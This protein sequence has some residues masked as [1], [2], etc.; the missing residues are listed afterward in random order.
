MTHSRVRPWNTGQR[1]HTPSPRH[2]AAS[3]P[4]TQ[5][6]G[7][8]PRHHDTQPRQALEHR[9]KVTH[10]ITT[11]HSLVRPWNT[12]QRS[13]IASPRHTAA[14]GPGTQVKGH[15]T[16]SR[17]SPGTWIKGHTPRHHDTQPRQA[18]EH[19]S[20]VTHSVTTTHS[21]IRPWNTGQRS[22]TLSPR[23]TAASIP[24]TQVKGHIFRHHDTVASGPKRQ[25]KAHNVLITILFLNTRII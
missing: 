8:T 13:H 16:H 25:I 1:S 19:R 4:G 2:T 23:H 11:T 24:G 3:G 10:P 7:H 18:L 5:V 22:H 20:K 21:R 14:S 15:T 12:G 6:K 17:F 9:S